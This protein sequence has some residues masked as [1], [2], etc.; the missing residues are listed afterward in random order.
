MEAGQTWLYA[1]KKQITL[2][3]F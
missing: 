3:E 2:L 1:E